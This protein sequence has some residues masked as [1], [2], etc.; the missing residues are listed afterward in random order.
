MTLCLNLCT[1]KQDNAVLLQSVVLSQLGQQVPDGKN[2]NVPTR[3]AYYE[4]VLQVCHLGESCDSWIFK[5][6][7]VGVNIPV[8]TGHGHLQSLFQSACDKTAAS[9]DGTTSR[10]GLWRFGGKLATNNV[11]LTWKVCGFGL[12]LQQEDGMFQ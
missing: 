5:L 2:K 9:L 12:V 4:H 7:K 8:G 1:N 10:N 3:K 6:V 11:R